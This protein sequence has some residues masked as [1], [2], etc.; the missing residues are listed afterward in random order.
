MGQE[1]GMEIWGQITEVDEG[2]SLATNSFWNKTLDD[3][4]D[5]SMALALQ[6]RQYLVHSLVKKGCLNQIH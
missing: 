6:K 5:S 2:S 3:T 1:G 4:A